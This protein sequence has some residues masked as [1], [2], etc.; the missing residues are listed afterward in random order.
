MLKRNKKNVLIGVCALAGVALTSVGFATWIVGVTNTDAS[1]KYNVQVDNVSS[2]TVYLTCN[3][4][5]GNIKIGETTPKKDKGKT[6]IA[7]TDDLSSFTD[8]LQFSIKDITLKIGTSV[9]ADVRPNKLK[10]SLNYENGLNAANV[11]TEGNNLLT[12]DGSAEKVRTGSNYHY[13]QLE[14]TIDLTYGKSGDASNLNMVTDD[15][16]TNGYK[17]YTFT[18]NAKNEY[19]S[20][21]LWGNYFG[22]D[23]S[24]TAVNKS[25]VTYYNALYAEKPEASLNLDHMLKSAG[26]AHQEIAAMKKALS[27][28]AKLTISIKA[29]HE[30]A[31]I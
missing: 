8:A 3:T 6:D 5:P 26:E 21:L 4:T 7:G 28:D 15:V 18:K 22:N 2:D 16:E 13:L 9:T 29:V 14:E 25:P 23:T 1:L 31:H 12:K 17:T 10:L 30:E 11:V 24:K 19:V 20:S 27:G